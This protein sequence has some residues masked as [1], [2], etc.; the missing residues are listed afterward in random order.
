MNENN[1]RIT[2]D[3]LRGMLV[4]INLKMA[5]ALGANPCAAHVLTKARELAAVTIKGIEAERELS[6]Q[7]SGTEQ[8]VGEK[9]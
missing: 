1:I 2:T 6:A 4:E 3:D 5:I 7:T 9:V 8:A